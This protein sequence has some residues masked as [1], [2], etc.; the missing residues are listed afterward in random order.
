LSD[1][2]D[3]QTRTYEARYVLEGDAASAPLGSTVTIRITNDDRRSEVS[4]PIAAV[5]N[6][7]NRTGVWLLDRGASTVRF[8]P[9][10][11]KQ[12]GSETAIVTGI[13]LGQEL[14]ALGAHLLSD[15]ASV[16]TNTQAQAAN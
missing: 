12:L 8:A 9:V 3:P 11:I 4:I 1:A 15:G 7:G 13:E 10:Q 5:L 2:A 14:V 6:D 16:R